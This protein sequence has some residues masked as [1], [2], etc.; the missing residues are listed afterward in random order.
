MDW[1]AAV[2][3]VTA[4][5]LNVY[6]L[7]TVWKHLVVPHCFPLP[8]GKMGSYL[9]FIPPPRLFKVSSRSVPKF[10]QP[11]QMH[12]AFLFSLK[13]TALAQG[14]RELGDSWTQHQQSQPHKAQ[15]GLH[16]LVVP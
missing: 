8:P 16:K 5:E 1:L 7:D 13:Y 6:T 9:K 14:K 15:S 11:T 12:K 4:Q 10:T 2:C 3:G